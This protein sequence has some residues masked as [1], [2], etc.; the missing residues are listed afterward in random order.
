VSAPREILHKGGS[1]EANIARGEARRQV[2]HLHQDHS[3]LQYFPVVHEHKQYF[4]LLIVMYTEHG[5]IKLY[6]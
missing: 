6:I 2:L 3:H 1:Q 5:F 4:S